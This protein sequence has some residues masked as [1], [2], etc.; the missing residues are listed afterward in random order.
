[1]KK[2]LNKDIL[3]GFEKYKYSSIDT[4]PISKYVMHP[5]WDR[6]VEYVPK[7][8]AP[9]IL[10]LGG[11]LFALCSFLLFVYY[12]DDYNAM[13]Y[14]STVKIPPFVWILSSIFI[15][16]S[17]TLD[18]I[19]GKQA[20]RTNTSSPIGELLDH[21]I[22]SLVMI[23]IVSNFY[24]IFGRDPTYSI[25]PFF[26]LVFTMIIST[27]FCLS[28]VEK[29]ITGVLYLPWTYDLSMVFTTVMYLIIAI[30]G[31]EFLH[32]YVL[33]ES[34]IIC[35]STAVT[36]YNIYSSYI[37]KTIISKSLIDSIR[38]IIPI[39][40]HYTVVILW[41]L[42]SPNN[43]IEKKPRLVYLVTGIIL[44]NITI[45][46]IVSGMSKTIAPIFNELTI[47]LSCVAAFCTLFKVNFASEIIISYATL[48][49]II[50]YHFKYVV[51]IH[52]YVLKASERPILKVLFNNDGDLLFTSAKDKFP[53]LWRSYNGE[54]LGTF[55]GHNGAVGDLSVDYTSTRLLTAA[56]DYNARLFDV[57]TGKLLNTILAKYRVDQ[58]DFSYTAQNFILLIKDKI[59]IYDTRVCGNSIQTHDF[60]Q[61][62]DKVMY[63]N[64][65]SL[66]VGFS[67]GDVKEINVSSGKT[68]NSCSTN[69]H[70]GKISVLKKSYDQEFYI[71]GSASKSALLI[72]AN[73]FQPL[74]EFNTE[75]PVTTACIS[76]TS[77]H[78]IICC[79]EEAIKV[80]TSGKS[81]EQ[82]GATIYDSIYNQPIASIR[83]H[84]GAINSVEY[85]PDGLGFATGGEDGIVFYHKFD[86]DYLRIAE[87]N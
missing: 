16:L 58:C 79:G 87:E 52:T 17:H 21:G 85:S 62:I 36:L 39:I 20:R 25:S 66:V 65:D 81:T 67:G 9:N 69:Q 10:T 26:F 86:S 47:F 57:E 63:G 82:F 6:V 24:T 32:N 27:S 41:V 80:T 71:S 18:G 29:Y 12:D 5:F 83:E 54:K 22:D 4:S 7:W 60:G 14:A 30:F 84:I 35:Y 64:L 37:N 8:V 23:F 56:M 48:Y 72:D 73:S 45:H 44:S 55:N 3:L 50:Y 74:T 68:I 75:L 28:H 19:D 61:I 59:E 77:H 70:N 34:I 15:F 78:V 13:S 11:F 53:T 40:T 38:P 43:I 33:K 2:Y 76:P 1:M 31:N 42:Y 46:I 51:G 49:I